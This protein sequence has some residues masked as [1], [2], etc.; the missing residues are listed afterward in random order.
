MMRLWIELIALRNAYSE[1]DFPEPVGPVTRK[2]PC[3]FTMISRMAFSSI[4]EKP[5]LSKLKKILP[6]V[7]RRS[8]TLSP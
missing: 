5:S 3:G 1:V 8:E 4:C 7:S 6:R 2:I